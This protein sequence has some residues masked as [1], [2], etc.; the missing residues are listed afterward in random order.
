MGNKTPATWAL[1][2]DSVGPSQR[3]R[4]PDVRTVQELLIA[5]GEDPGRVD[6]RWGDCT[7]G[8][9][10]SFKTRSR[11]Y[12][13]AFGA[14]SGFPQRNVGIFPTPTCG[15]SRPIITDPKLRPGDYTL[16]LLAAEADILI[17]L[18]GAPGMKGIRSLHGWF[19]SNGIK[20]NRGAEA[21]RGNRANYGLHNRPSFAIQRIDRAFKRGPVRMDCTTYVN[22]MLSVY[23]DGTAHNATYDASLSGWGGLG[24]HLARGR[25][26]FE[27]VERPVEGK[28]AA[29][30]FVTAEDIMT[31]VEAHPERLYVLE[32]GRSKKIGGEIKRGFVTHMALMHEGHVYECTLSAKEGLD[33]VVDRPLSEFVACKGSAIFYLFREPACYH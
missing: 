14:K 17:P 18:P 15:F 13:W 20:Y 30:N 12:R 26:G 32:V 22:L 8:A 4:G 9:L 7:K 24:P 23:K 19:K 25:F 6:G 11:F 5:A 27:L 2:E 3:N 29:N 10:E 28:K 1:I 21:G 16:L 33:G 31:A